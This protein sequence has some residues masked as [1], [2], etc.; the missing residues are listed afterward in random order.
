MKNIKN[1]IFENFKNL[2]MTSKTPKIQILKKTSKSHVRR[3]Q[4]NNSHVLENVHSNTET[5]KLNVTSYDINFKIIQYI[6]ATFYRYFTPIG[7]SPS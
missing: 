1:D 2:K 7:F 3:L 5:F 6:E 4:N